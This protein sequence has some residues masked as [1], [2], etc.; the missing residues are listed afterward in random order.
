MNIFLNFYEKRINYIIL[1]L[2]EL[3]LQNDYDKI[4]FNELSNLLKLMKGEI[5]SLNNKNN[6]LE[7][8]N[9]NY[10]LLTKKLESQIIKNASM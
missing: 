6:L 10:D 9:K 3:Y 8:E 1:K 4:N 5:N 7:D 2:D